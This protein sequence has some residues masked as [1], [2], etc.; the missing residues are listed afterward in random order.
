MPRVLRSASLLGLGVLG[1]GLL[2]GCVAN[3]PAATHTALTVDSSATD[4]A[5]SANE[6]P[7]GSI[8]FSVTNS[9]DQVTEFYLLAEDGLRIV[10]EAEN[11][12][13]GLSRDLVVQLDA[14]SYFTACKPGM[15][16]DGVGKAEFTATKTDAAAT[17]DV[18]LAAQIVTANTNYGSYV[19]DQIDQLVTG[20]D[21]FAAAYSAGDDGTAR[22]LYASTRVHWERVETI[23]E[24]FGDLDPKLDLREAD[25]EEGQ[26]WTGWHAIEKDLWPQDAE[27]GFV[28]YTADQRAA[29]TE[30][31]VAD[32]ATLHEKIEGLTFTLSQQTNGA[33]GLLDEVATGKVTGE[34]EIWSHTDLWD[35]Q[36]NVDGAKVLYDGVRPILLKT[37]ADLA[38]SLD[39]EFGS[40]QAL[41]DAQRVGDGFTLYTDLTPA[42]IR[43]LADQVN[44]LGEP[45]NQLT[46]ALVL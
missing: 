16:G 20:T 38:A 39:T 5:V 28:A 44:A 14:G 34:E 41:L 40:L 45:L 12:G 7:A 27:A 31:L 3:N 42:E 25:L 11:I 36:A 15:T 26:N 37:D 43:A 29:L 46:A 22:S 32:T 35:F 1:I 24:S 17:V 9:G 33:I 23:A 10:G 21:A 18:D 2:S 8:R 30:Q 6:A 4:C 13:P 19:S